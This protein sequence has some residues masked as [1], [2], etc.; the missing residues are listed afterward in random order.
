MGKLSR[1]KGSRFENSV[2]KMLIEELGDIIPDSEN[3]RRNLTQYQTNSQP[4][5]ILADL[6]ALEMK[7]YA[8]GNGWF[9]PD[10]WEQS[11]Q[12][13]ALLNMIP[14]LIYKYDRQ[15]VRVVLPLYVVGREFALNDDEHDF[16]REGNAI[17]P[18]LMDFETG[19]MILREWL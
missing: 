8:K 17:A 9:K 13:A 19:C 12:S 16:P 5:V 10:W 7:H 14:V 2:I 15:Q 11:K 4:D 3:L 18:I 6:F 1:D